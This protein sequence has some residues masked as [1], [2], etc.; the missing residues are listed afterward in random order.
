MTVPTD[1]RREGRNGRGQNDSV[2][3]T[4]DGNLE[5]HRHLFP[6]LRGMIFEKIDYLAYVWNKEIEDGDHDGSREGSMVSPCVSND[7]RSAAIKRRDT[8]KLKTLGGAFLCNGVYGR[9]GP[10]KLVKNDDEDVTTSK[11]KRDEDT[12][13]GQKV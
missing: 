3:P 9:S 11:G 8:I 6:T 10:K 1:G 5:I 7:N 13:N 4:K 12:N 2:D